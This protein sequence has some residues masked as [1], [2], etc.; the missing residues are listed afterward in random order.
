[1]GQYPYPKY[2]KTLNPNSDAWVSQGVFTISLVTF[3]TPIAPGR[4]A[5]FLSLATAGDSVPLP[6][7]LERWLPAWL[8]SHQR[9]GTVLDGD[10]ALLCAP[11]PAAHIMYKASVSSG[12][13]S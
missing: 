4:A 5:L 2:P 12:E 13:R 9:S 6:L 8:D 3:V 11:P 1:M 10:S 7:K